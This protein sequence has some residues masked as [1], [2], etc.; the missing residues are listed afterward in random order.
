MTAVRPIDPTV[1]TPSSGTVGGVATQVSHLERR[2]RNLEAARG[3]LSSNS[4]TSGQINAGSIQS[5]HILAGSIQAGHI[6]VGAV[7]AD[8]IDALAINADHIQSNAIITRHLESD[9]IYAEH[10]VAGEIETAHLD[11][12]AVTAEKISSGTL[13]T[14]WASAGELEGGLITGGLFQSA[15]VGTNPRIYIDSNGIFATNGAGANSLSYSTATGNVIISGKFFASNDSVVPADAVDAA[16]L[17]LITQALGTITSGFIGSATVSTNA[18]PGYTGSRVELNSSGF[19]AYNSSNQERLSFNTTSGALSIKTAVSGSRVVMDGNGLKFYQSDGVTPRIEFDATTGNA[20][21]TGGLSALSANLG[22][23]TAGTITLTGSPAYIRSGA[24]SDYVQFDSTGVFAMVGGNKAAHLTTTGLQILAGT[25]DSPPAE[26]RIKWLTS[27]GQV[28]GDV[29]S[30][31]ASSVNTATLM[32]YAPGGGTWRSSVQLASGST[33]NTSLLWSQSPDG[34]TNVYMQV[35]ASNTST[36]NDITI[37]VGGQLATLMRA[38]GFT[39]FVLYNTTQTIT[40][41]K[42]FSAATTFSNTVSVTNSSVTAF[43][44]TGRING[45]GDGVSAT[46]WLQSGGS[47]YVGSGVLYL[48]ASAWDTNI[49]KVATKAVRVNGY[50]DAHDSAGGQV[51]GMDTRL[52]SLPGYSSSYYPV[53][54][55]QY[56]YHYFV[57]D[58]GYTGYHNQYGWTATS[59]RR[60]KRM[61]VPAHG[62]LDRLRKLPVYEYEYRGL[63]GDGQMFVMAQEFYDDLF[64]ELKLQEPTQLVPGGKRM[65]NP[66]DVTGVL[67]KS[68]QEL[69]TEVTAD[70]RAARERVETLET[71]VGRLAEEIATLKETA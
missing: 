50:I 13:E 10:I 49:Q 35:K 40:G 43:N 29:H 30:Y 57:T 51:V 5:G 32:A 17:S 53:H 7:T 8:A 46:G 60:E 66:N 37:N 25:S 26:R 34:A 23:I 20:N 6:D 55:A 64:P 3:R 48:G 44:V 41:A 61:I 24:G 52:G 11:V 70:L 12:G 4:I 45:N 2:V 14:L 59:D 47:T 36:L 21:L 58:Q 65:L 1:S 54:Y 18:T 28:T 39:S 38:D 9:I 15:P 31:T 71:I 27:G 16:S 69:D 22:T 33:Q 56:S 42:T 19:Y 62:T 63:P 67:L 68:V